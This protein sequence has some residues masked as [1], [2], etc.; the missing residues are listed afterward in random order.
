MFQ[1]GG[2]GMNDGGG[3]TAWSPMYFLAMAAWQGTADLFLLKLRLS[4]RRY[5]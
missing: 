3:D 2:L 4:H 1:T 5:Y